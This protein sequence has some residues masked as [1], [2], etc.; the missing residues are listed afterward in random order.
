M[1]LPEKEALLFAEERRLFYVALT[2][3]KGKL[4]IITNKQPISEFVNELITTY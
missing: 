1:F 4:Y 3:T 2:R